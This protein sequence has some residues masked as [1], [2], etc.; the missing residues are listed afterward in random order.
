MP[1]KVRFRTVLYHYCT[2]LTTVQYYSIQ[3]CCL[4]W[5]WHR[6]HLLTCSPCES[7]VHMSSSKYYCN[8]KGFVEWDLLSYTVQHCTIPQDGI[9]TVIQYMHVYLIVFLAQLWD[10]S[11]AFRSHPIL[12]LHFNTCT[13]VYIRVQYPR[14]DSS[15]HI[16]TSHVHVYRFCWRTPHEGLRGEYASSSFELQ[17]IRASPSKVITVGRFL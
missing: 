2:V 13:Y 17:K 5:C 12:Y 10:L 1:R 6:W 7:A 11:R 15:L 9:Y 3:K 4:R 8:G 14:Y 16:W